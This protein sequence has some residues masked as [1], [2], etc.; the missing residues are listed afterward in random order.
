VRDPQG[1]V[2]FGYRIDFSTG[3]IASYYGIEGMNWTNPPLFDHADHVSIDGV[4][5]LYVN[6]GGKVQDVGWIS[7]GALYWISN[8]I[9]Q[10]LT[11]D[12]MFALAESAA[13]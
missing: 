13:D 11:N 3:N 1:H 7:H 6:T 4:H 10:D 12:Q 8:T 5:Y 2:H 9:F